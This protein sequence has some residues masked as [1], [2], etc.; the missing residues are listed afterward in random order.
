MEGPGNAI[1][2]S[3]LF[4]LYAPF[5]RAFLRQRGL[6]D[7]WLDDAVQD[8]F[9]VAHNCGGHLPGPATAK[10]WL[11]EIA[12]RIAANAKRKQHRTGR[13]MVANQDVID[14]IERHASEPPAARI[15]D[16]LRRLSQIDRDVFFRFYVLGEDCPVIAQKLDVPVGTVYRRL[17]TARKHFTEL[18]TC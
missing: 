12:K 7:L 13:V 1:G 3:Q 5:V 14:M 9:I 4:R 15:E 2:A 6:Y 18:L 11:G 10:S 16:V 17:H 8:V